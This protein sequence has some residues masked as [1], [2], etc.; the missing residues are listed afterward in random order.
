M[1]T[2]GED[3][4]AAADSIRTLMRGPQMIQG[5]AADVVSMLAPFAMAG[6]NIPEETIAS[7]ARMAMRRTAAVTDLQLRAETYAALELPARFGLAR[8]GGG[9]SPPG[10]PRTGMQRAFD[11]VL[12]TANA[13][14]LG[15]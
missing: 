14:G 8:S 13:L 11:Q 5:A 4:T 9:T 15:D 2:L 10:S 1:A 3:V 7:G 12:D 6:I